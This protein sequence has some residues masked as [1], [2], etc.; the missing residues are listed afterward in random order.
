MVDLAGTWVVQAHPQEG[1]SATALNPH[2][3]THLILN[4]FFLLALC[5]VH[6]H[7]LSS[8]PSMQGRQQYGASVWPSS[9]VVGKVHNQGRECL[10]FTTLNSR[11]GANQQL[12]KISH[13]TE[14]VLLSQSLAASTMA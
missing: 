11:P 9:R 6:Q 14:G 3:H 8:R 7:N 1:T 2:T 12:G 13:E 4:T 10:V 5:C